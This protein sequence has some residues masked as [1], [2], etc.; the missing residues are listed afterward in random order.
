MTYTFLTHK[1]RFKEHAREWQSNTITVMFIWKSLCLYEKVLFIH[2]GFRM[3]DFPYLF[4][5]CIYTQAFLSYPK[6]TALVSPYIYEDYDVM[7][8][9]WNIIINKQGCNEFDI[10]H[11]SQSHLFI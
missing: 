11:K 2:S 9:L 1:G 7:T 3:L 10:N 4:I 8:A 5:T 6:P